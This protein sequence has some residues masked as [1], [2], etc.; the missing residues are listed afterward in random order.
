MTTDRSPGSSDDGRRLLVYGSYGYTGDLV[1]RRAIMRGLEPIVAGRRGSEL[2]PQADDLGLEARAFDLSNPAAVAGRLRG[3]DVVLNCAGPFEDTYEPLVEACLERGIDY[4]DITGEIP[5]YEGIREYDDRA[6]EAG[7][8]LLPGVGF[9]V[10]PTD[11]LAAHLHERL[12]GASKLELALEGFERVSKGTA[13]T[14]LRNLDGVLVRDGGTIQRI[15][16][17]RR[18]KPFDFG[19]GERFATA[20][21]FGD[22]STAEHST[23]ID[24]V[25]VYA[26]VPRFLEPLL[27]T[28]GALAPFFSLPPVRSTLEAMVDATVS[29]PSE[30]QRKN[31]TT[32]IVGRAADGTDSVAARLRTPEPYEC[33]VRTS[34]AAVERALDGQAPPGYQTPAT[35]FGPDFVL[36]VADI[37]RTRLA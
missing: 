22:V 24:N 6:R 19:D 20:I 9:D 10:V 26:A 15:P 12:P 14:A 18:S 30:R 29:G 7:V 3:V 28:T 34:L 35:A 13:R 11:C 36:S 23:G 37:E 25:T 8:T 32:R 17:G 5:V 4:L 33:T 27:R 1:V 31:A 21:P 16:F 2:N